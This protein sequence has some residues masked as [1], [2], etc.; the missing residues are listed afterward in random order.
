[1][2]NSADDTCVG[3]LEQC[4]G[5]GFNVS[6]SCCDAGTA[7]YAKHYWYAQC[8]TVEEVTL[9]VADNG[10]DGRS[11]DREEMPDDI[12]GAPASPVYTPSTIMGC[13]DDTCVPYNDKCGGSGFNVSAPCCQIQGMP[14]ISCY[15]KHVSHAQCLTATDA[16][17]KSNTEAWDGRVLTCEEMP[18]DVP[19]E[20]HR[21]PDTGRRLTH[22]RVPPLA[23]G[24]LACMCP[25]C[26][27][28]MLHLLIPVAVLSSLTRSH[29]RFSC[30]GYDWHL[31]MC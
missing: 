30:T 27:W 21:L 24:Q 10:W 23:H 8:L 25:P 29:M 19:L 31:S 1:M 17:A 16:M 14:E 15:I 5:T 20:P 6:A 18:E 11:L 7:C 9:N 3:H 22:V 4:S 28:C 13:D 2:L 12:L 26:K